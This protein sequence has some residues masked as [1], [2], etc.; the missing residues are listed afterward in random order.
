MSQK[1]IMKDN[2]IHNANIVMSS[3]TQNVYKLASFVRLGIKRLEV[4]LPVFWD[5]LE[6]M[7][8]AIPFELIHSSPSL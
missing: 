4:V 5:M 6:S 2:Y 3:S 7:T 8:F 1:W